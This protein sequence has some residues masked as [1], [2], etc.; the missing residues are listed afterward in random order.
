MIIISDYVPAFTRIFAASMFLIT[1]TLTDSFEKKKNGR[2]KK[3]N[4]SMRKDVRRPVSEI[5]LF[6]L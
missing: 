1:A 2:E 6:F 4:I 3:E 5:R